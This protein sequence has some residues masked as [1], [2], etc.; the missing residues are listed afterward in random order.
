MDRPRDVVYRASRLEGDVLVTEWQDLGPTGAT[1]PG[2]WVPHRR[3]VDAWLIRLALVDPRIEHAL[4][5]RLDCTSRAI[6]ATYATSS[7]AR[8]LEAFDYVTDMLGLDMPAGLLGVDA[9]TFAEGIA[10]AR[11]RIEHQ[12]D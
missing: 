11:Q 7:A 12:S 9:N 4:A 8:Q 10:A 3:P 1:P 6:E 2:E 5:A